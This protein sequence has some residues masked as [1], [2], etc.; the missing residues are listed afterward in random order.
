[1]KISTRRLIIQIFFFFLQNPVLKNFIS[2]NIYQGKLKMIC[3]PGLNCYSCPAAVMSCPIG[4]IQLFF[5]GVKHNLSLFVTGFLFS[6]GVIFGRLICGYVCPMGLIQ[7]L[8]YKIKTPKKLVRFRFLRYIKYLIL[9]LFVIILPILISHELSGFGEPWF[10]KY[11]CPSGTVF[12]AIPLLTAN[13]FLRSSA[14]VLLII[15]LAIAMLILLTSIFIYRPFCRILCPLGAIYAPF[16]KIAL[17]KIRYD[18]D[19]CTSC[20]N[21]A[22]ACK[23]MLEPAT[24]PNSPE[25]VRCGDCKTA[26]K[27]KALK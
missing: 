3:T 2:G 22:K 27:Y 14:G 23:I 1:M 11:I 13:T 24:K 18:K 20:N 5:A 6:I 7:D 12:G 17:L 26:C 25:C 19:K 8:T 4:A 9:A 21:C 15:K 10:C 16:N